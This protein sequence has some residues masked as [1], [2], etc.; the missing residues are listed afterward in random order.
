MA[1]KNL[2]CVLIP[3]L[4][5]GKHVSL[6]SFEDLLTRLTELEDAHSRYLLK[7]QPQFREDDDL[8]SVSEVGFS[9]FLERN[10]NNK[11]LVGVSKRGWILLRVEPKPFTVSKGTRNGNDVVAFLLPDWTE[12]FEHELLS[13]DEALERV[14]SWLE[15]EADAPILS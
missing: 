9:F 14:K 12:H 5:E 2:H 4:G 7:L 1:N 15:D 13:R 11:A 10:A 3:N 8:G 6:R